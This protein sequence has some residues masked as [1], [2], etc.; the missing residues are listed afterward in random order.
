MDVKQ[1]LDVIV[2]HLLIESLYNV[3]Y[4]AGQILNPSEIAEFY[5][6]SKTPVLQAL[7]RLETEKILELSNNGKYKLVCPDANNIKDIC[8]TRF[9][10]ESYAVSKLID[11]F[12]DDMYSKLMVHVNKCKSVSEVAETKEILKADYSFH[13]C[14]IGL[15]RNETISEFYEPMINRFILLKYTSGYRRD[16]Q[17]IIE[18][19]YLFHKE[20]TELLRQKKRA[21]LLEYIQEHIY[22]EE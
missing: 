16:L 19:S 6:I 9:M 7:K 12:D 3:E 20:I 14:L 13:K 11:E 21:E 22:F 15:L 4:K 8:E 10:F 18:N 1:N 17:W 5:N 2:Y